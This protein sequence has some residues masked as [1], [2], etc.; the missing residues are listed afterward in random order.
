MSN[1][2][3]G[4]LSAKP[5][6]PP[7]NHNLFLQKTLA[8]LHQLQNL[9]VLDLEDDTCDLELDRYFKSA[10]SPLFMEQITVSIC[11]LTAY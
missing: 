4:Y 3:I 9:D 10:L 6:E 8:A 2:K 5:L 1:K 11:Y 7:T